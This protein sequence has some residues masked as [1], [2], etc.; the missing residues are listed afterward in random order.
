MKKITQE[1]FDRA[2]EMGF[3]FEEACKCGN[4][5]ECICKL[6]KGVIEYPEYLPTQT[7]FAAALR[8]NCAIHTYPELVVVVEDRPKWTGT[9]SFLSEHLLFKDSARNLRDTYCDAM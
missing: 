5:S 2:K 8:E 7:E 6:V 3:N 1:L 4:P 9:V